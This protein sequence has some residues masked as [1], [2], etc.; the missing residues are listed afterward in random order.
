MYCWRPIWHKNKCKILVL[1]RNTSNS[2]SNHN[3]EHF[4]LIDEIKVF[5]ATNYLCWIP[6]IVWNAQSDYFNDSFDIWLSVCVCAGWLWLIPHFSNASGNELR[7]WVEWL[8]NHTNRYFMIVLLWKWSDGEN[9]FLSAYHTY[10]IEDWTQA[11]REEKK[12]EPK[13]APALHDIQ[14]K[15]WSDTSIE[16]IFY[17]QTKIIRY[18]HT[19]YINRESCMLLYFFIKSMYALKSH[20]LIKYFIHFFLFT[21]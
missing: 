13:L 10:R 9:Y 12:R 7:Q 5:H 16:R 4:D 1:L 2:Y 20:L 11:N 17:M 6:N 18:V 21:F 15:C 14:R 8:E 19:L 3:S